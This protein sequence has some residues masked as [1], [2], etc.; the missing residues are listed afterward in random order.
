[1]IPIPAI[2]LKDGKVV[3]LLR[4]D[5]KTV[6]VYSQRPEEIARQF[7]EGGAQRIHVVD[8]EGA[9]AGKP[10]NR[11]SLEKIL[12]SVRTPVQ[13][14]GGIRDLK[15]AHQYFE[16]GAGW[17]IFGTQACLDLG[18][19]KEA[20]GEFGGKA[21]VGLDASDGWIAIDGW[22]KI[23]RTPALEL[24][25]RVESL[26]GKTVVYTDISRDG[27]LQG[28]NLLQIKKLCESVKIDVIASGG[29]SSLSDLA[30]MVKMNQKNLLGTIVGTALYERRFTLAEAFKTCLQ[31]G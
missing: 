13:M 27:A 24:A 8:L 1:M 25:Q 9:L 11:S 31:K 7:E 28:P 20:I 15:T 2:D 23:T 3:R 14:G 6:K 26:G 16:M 17:V 22:T 4:G 21:L 10:K 18:F 29:V 19:L 5:F 12:K 30:V